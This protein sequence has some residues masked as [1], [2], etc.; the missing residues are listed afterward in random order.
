[1]MAGEIMPKTRILDRETVGAWLLKA[2]PSVY[3]VESALAN[4]VSFD[5]WRLA[6]TYRVGLISPRDPVV[7]WLSG[8]ERGIVAAGVVRDRPFTS[9]GGTEYWIDAEEKVKTRPYL[10][11]DL[12]PIPKIVEDELVSAPSFANAEVIRIRQMGNPS[13]LTHEELEVV[14]RLMGPQAA[15]DAG[16]RE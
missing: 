10:P 14:K 2:N 4:G 7:L 6:P 12:V 13:Y 3:D 11:V 8:P 1:M 9:K 16:W 5:S 15:L